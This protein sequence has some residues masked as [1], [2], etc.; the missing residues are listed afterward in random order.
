MILTVRDVLAL[1]V[2]AAGHPRVVAGHTLL[3]RPVRWVHI[4][5]STDLTDLLEGGE[6]VLSTGLPL[7]GAPEAVSGYLAMLGA[8]QVAGLVVELGTHLHK[9]P[10]GLEAVAEAAGVPVVVLDTEI[11]YVEV[12]E[13]VHRRIVAEQYD[14]VEFARTTHEVFTSLNIARAS[15]TDI[16]TRASQILDAPL[17]LEDLSRHVLAHC[18]A[19][20]KTAQL[21]ENWAE[22]SRLHDF[23]GTGTTSGWSTVS[24]GVGTERWGRLVL[25]VEVPD[26]T[27]AKMVLE[28]AA[29]S[30]QL[31]RMLQ[32]ERDALVVHALGGLFDDMLNGRIGDETEALVRASALGLR[33][34]HNYVPVVVRIPQRP[35]AHPLTQGE[36][37]RRLLT[38]LR[39]AVAETGHTA[40]VSIRREGTVSAVMSCTDPDD[41]LRAVCTGLGTRLSKRDGTESWVAGTAPSSPSLLA[42]AREITEAEHVADVGVTMPAA[43]RLY[44]S[45]DVRLRG[46]IALLR[47]DHRVQA[48][49]ETEL[50]RLLEHDAR[51]NDDLLGLL[52]TY[53]DNSGSKTETA[54]DTGLSRPTL[55]AR[56]QTIERILGILLDTAESRTSLH[57]ALMIVDSS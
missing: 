29:Q 12:T 19:G 8:Q 37:D 2:V 41:A 18:A 26:A 39:Q 56:L 10:D 20:T 16:V 25:P 51:N 21:L 30:L 42:A 46:L 52:R 34:N 57:T 49:A 23:P 48:F 50:G 24:V 47:H 17:V 31:H 9:V 40:I 5:E 3:A 22:R 36:I 32:Q 54:R 28:R 1:P 38:A 7:T 45:T 27:R 13:Q 14:E 35:N 43:N 15:S 6:L 44:R 11:R 4:S 33:M 53:L 55:Y